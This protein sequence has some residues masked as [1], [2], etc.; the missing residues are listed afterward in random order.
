M[1]VAVVVGAQWGDEGKGRLVDYLA[2]RAYLRRIEEL[3]GAPL[4]L[5]SVGL[6]RAQMVVLP[7]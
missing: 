5:V 6:D 3:A 4:R 2:A 1:S 7:A